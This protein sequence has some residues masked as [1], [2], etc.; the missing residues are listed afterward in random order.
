MF[1]D[2]KISEKEGDDVV[3]NIE[4]L[5]KYWQLWDAYLFFVWNATIRKSNYFPVLVKV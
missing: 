2:S 4:N 5:S 3:K 1:I